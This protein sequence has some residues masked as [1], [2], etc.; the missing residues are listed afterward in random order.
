VAFNRVLVQYGIERVLY[1]LAESTHAEKFV[2]KGAMLFVL[3][4]GAQHRETRDVDLLGFGENSLDEMKRVFEEICAT[5]VV[6]DGLV[7]EGVSVLAI[8]ALQEYGGISVKISARLDA[9][10]ITVNVDVGFGDKVTPR[11]KRV[12]FPVLLDF[13]APR[14][15]AYPAETVVAEKFQAMVALGERNTRMKDFFDVLYLSR[16]FDFDGEVLLEAVAETFKRRST[17]LPLAIPVALT[18]TFATANEGMWRAFLRRSDQEQSDTFLAVIQGLRGFLTPMLHAMGG[19]A[20]EMH[21]DKEKWRPKR[22][23][24]RSG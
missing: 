22:E 20:F 16:A 12:A 23:T 10:R 19:E 7:F 2:L 6:D 17:P 5:Q 3:W 11:P 1:R 18:D 24:A 14:V 21:W 9:A 4:E 8:T 13:P 15:R